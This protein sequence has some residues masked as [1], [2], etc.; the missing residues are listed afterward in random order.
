[1]RISFSE[2]M[3]QFYLDEVLQVLRFEEA[4]RNEKQYRGGCRI[5]GSSPGSSSLSIRRCD[6]A[7]QCFKCKRHGSLLDLYMQ[8]NRILNPRQAILSLCKELKK[9]PVYENMEYLF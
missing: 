9:N 7:F 1:M 8:V 5:H 3:S 2:T 6:G 4:S